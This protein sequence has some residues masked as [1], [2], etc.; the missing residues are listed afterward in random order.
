MSKASFPLNPP[1]KTFHPVKA[2]LYLLLRTAIWTSLI[3]ILGIYYVKEGGVSVAQRLPP[4]KTTFKNSVSLLPAP[5]AVSRQEAGA[6]VRT[7]STDPLAL[8]KTG[9]K[10]I[11]PRVVRA[12][13][14]RARNT[15]VAIP[16]LRPMAFGESGGNFAQLGTDKPERTPAAGPGPAAVSPAYAQE[17]LVLTSAALSRKIHIKGSAPVSAAAEKRYTGADKEAEMLR[18]VLRSKA[19]AAEAASKQ[20]RREQLMAGGIIMLS[21]LVIMLVASRVIKAWKTLEK[22]E[23]KHWTLNP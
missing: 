18:V 7:A 9:N 4:A 15:Q 2:A 8:I 19:E 12:S 3:L 23:G 22:P 5:S 14:Q 20:L 11:I 6:T 21:A 13:Q 16:R 17:G 10:P 1:K